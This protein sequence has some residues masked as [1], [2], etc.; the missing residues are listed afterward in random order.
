M[1]TVPRVS[2]TI[3]VDPETAR[4]LLAPR[5]DIVVE[6][7]WNDDDERVWAD[8]HPPPPPPLEHADTASV[9]VPDGGDRATFALQRGPMVGYRRDV[10]ARPGPDGQIEVTETTRCRLALGVWGVV[11]ARLMARSLRRTGA[12][13]TTRSPA[14]APP[15]S[16]DARSGTVLGVLLTLALVA[17]YLGTVMTQTITYAADE[18]GRGTSAQG[19][20]LAAVRV[21][22]LGSLVLVAMADQRGRRRLLLGS[23]GAACLFTVVGAVAPTLE[24]LT[25]SQ[26]LARAF[27]TASTLLLAVVAAEEMPA[28]ARAYAISVMTMTGA[29][30]AGMAVWALT[31]VDRAE[32]GWR[33]LY[34]MAVLGL[35]IVLSVRRRLPE[36]QRFVRPH[37]DA[38]VVRGHA[39]RFWAIGAALFC[40]SAFGAPSS[41]LLNDFLKDERGFSSSRIALFTVLTTTPAGIALVAGGRLAD[42][43]GRRVVVAVG[44]AG[45]SLIGAWASRL[46]VGRCG[47][48][49]WARPCSARWPSPPS[50]PTGPSCSRPRRGAR[51]TA[52]SR[53]SRWP[54]ARSG[55]WW[56]GR[57]PIAPAG[58]PT[59]CSC[60]CPSGCSWRCWP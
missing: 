55:C 31:F 33:V 37:R 50:G 36:S 59:G 22:A 19:G 2:Q 14:W 58:W 39:A 18:F 29:L 8:D 21:G 46:T 17:G 42:T 47:Q 60:S 9:T 41:Q 11:V 38:T 30:G 1:R 54:A 49:T 6:R 26:T 35:P 12:R 51:P 53:S 16:L 10:A 20:A 24:V 56:R 34:L 27:T 44:V 5:S 23:L 43:R 28:G 7:P 4:S 13:Q 3:M 32:W 45:G 52:S 15:E 57:W 40:S 25:V 48:P